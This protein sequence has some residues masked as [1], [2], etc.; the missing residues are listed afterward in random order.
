[1]AKRKKPKQKVVTLT[2]IEKQAL[3]SAIRERIQAE[4]HWKEKVQLQTEVVDS[5]LQGYGFSKEALMDL[6]RIDFDGIVTITEA[7]EGPT[8]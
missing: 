7:E 1:M 2:V 5:I 8:P 6:T 4:T 3:R